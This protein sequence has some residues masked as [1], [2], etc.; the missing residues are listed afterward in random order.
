MEFAIISIVLSIFIIPLPFSVKAFFSFKD[1]KIYFSLFYF[2]RI[3]L[4]NGYAEFKANKTFL[5]YS[6]KKAI[7]LYYD[8]LIKGNGETDV[9]NYINATK[10]RYA[11]ILDGYK[12][13]GAFCVLSV[14][15]TVNSAIYPV[16]KRKYPLVDFKGDVLISET[17]KTN[18]VIFDLGICFNILSITFMLVKNMF[19]GKK[20]V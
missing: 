16:L 12:S 10:I 11:V 5:H 9:I 14:I 17:N 13:V 8:D 3:R 15:N 6:D 18:G 4:K 20:N 2:R 7:A 19:G 1:K